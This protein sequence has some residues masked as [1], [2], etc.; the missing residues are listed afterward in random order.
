MPNKYK[1]SD[2]RPMK[3]PLDALKTLQ[4]DNDYVSDAGMCEWSPP[5][6]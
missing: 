2:I 3:T 6:S 5:L 4:I 1:L